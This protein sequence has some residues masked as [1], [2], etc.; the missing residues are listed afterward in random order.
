MDYF[1]LVQIVDSVNDLVKEP[2]SLPL[3]QPKMKTILL[4][5]VRNIVKQLSSWTVLH[6]QKQVFGSL[7]YFVELNEI[8]M[9]YKFKDVD[10]PAHSFYIANICYLLFFQYFNRHFLLRQLMDGQ[11]Y[12]S[13]ST[14][15]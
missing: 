9:S 10:F 2:A 8:G 4:F 3:S 11:F 7:N 15:P 5:L 14:L 1:K 6:N 12:F 13:K